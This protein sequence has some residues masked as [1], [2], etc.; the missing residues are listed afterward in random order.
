MIKHNIS[1]A[2]YKGRNKYV[3]IL[4]VYVYVF[5]SKSN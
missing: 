2:K 1:H 4:N 3:N 5:V